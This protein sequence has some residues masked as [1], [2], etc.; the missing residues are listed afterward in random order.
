MLPGACRDRRRAGGVFL[1]LGEKMVR[2]VIPIHPAK[3]C[4]SFKV[5]ETEAEGLT[6]MHAKDLLPAP[7]PLLRIRKWLNV[8]VLVFGANF[9]IFISRE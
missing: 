5:F 3:R 1:F 4:E 6:G 8:P 9:R 2:H 7:P